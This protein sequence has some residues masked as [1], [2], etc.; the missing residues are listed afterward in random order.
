MLGVVLLVV[1]H[2][3]AVMVFHL[4]EV[5]LIAEV[6]GEDRCLVRAIRCSSP[7]LEDECHI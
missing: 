6:L 3:R 4:P 7:G 5:K 2:L 1:T